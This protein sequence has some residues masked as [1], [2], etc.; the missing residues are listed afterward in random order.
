MA[1]I[2][3]LS[4][5]EFTVED[6]LRLQ[7]AA[8]ESVGD[9]DVLFRLVITPIDEIKE[10]YRN[11]AK[12]THYGVAGLITPDLLP[13]LK[14]CTIVANIVE[15]VRYNGLN[16]DFTIRSPG[17]GL[18]GIN[19]DD[20]I[21]YASD[22]CWIQ[23]ALC[24]DHAAYVKLLLIP[25]LF[26]RHPDPAVLKAFADG[27]TTLDFLVV[28]PKGIFG[29]W[30]AFVNREPTPEVFEEFEVEIQEGLDS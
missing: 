29:N 28:E 22:E 21:V 23:D 25:I 27:D 19:V 15:Q 7:A 14:G 5:D 30:E 6:V 18:V 11:W 24:G 10:M 12:G 3:E 13:E 26:G 8:S 2:V 1:R 16:V 4:S 17:G 20:E 9:L